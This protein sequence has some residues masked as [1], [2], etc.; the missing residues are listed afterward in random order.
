[1]SHD[2]Q[3]QRRPSGSGADD[4]GGAPVPADRQNEPGPVARGAA[5][6]DRGAAEF[7]RAGAAARTDAGTDPAAH[8]TTD[9]HA[10][11]YRHAGANGDSGTD[12]D[13][14]TH[15]HDGA[16]RN[17]DPHAGT[18]AHPGAMNLG[19]FCHF[20][21][22][23]RAAYEAVKGFRTHH[24]EALLHLVSDGGDDFSRLAATFGATYERYQESLGDAHEKS[25][26][27][28]KRAAPAAD[29][30]ERLKRMA[31]AFAG[32]LA[33]AEWILLLEPDVET[34]RTARAVPRFPLAGGDQGPFWSQ[35]LKAAFPQL[36][37]RYTG[38]GGSCVHREAFLRCFEEIPAYLFYQAKAYDARICHAQDAAHTFLFQ[39]SGLRT[40]RWEELGH[41]QRPD[42]RDHAFIHGNKQFYNLPSPLAP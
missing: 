39:A 29:Q 15:P 19:A 34:R 11:A 17:A 33:A 31:R 41:F 5:P 27:K 13:S 32:P 28:L 3:L 37:A 42:G 20:F 14:G 1:M 24:P 36:K 16:D 8:A 12:R 26:W 10:G 35:E 4:A 21:R 6:D 30:Y 25:N 7:H 2:R 18:D 22:H 23:D 38:C 40:G 9:T